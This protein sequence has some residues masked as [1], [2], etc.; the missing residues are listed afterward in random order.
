MSSNTE[1]LDESEGVVR[2][3]L[4][5]DL[6]FPQSE[7]DR[8]HFANVHRLPRRVDAT[9]SSTN[10]THTSPQIVVKLCKM[11]DKFTILKLA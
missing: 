11:K 7:V 4:V 10:S 8:M 5:K 9:H 2:S 6:K 1:N 3:F